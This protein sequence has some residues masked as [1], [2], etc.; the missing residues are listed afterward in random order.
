MTSGS[1]YFFQFIGGVKPEDYRG[2]RFPKA[3]YRR[4]PAK[5]VKEVLAVVPVQIDPWM[6]GWVVGEY[7]VKF[8]IRDTL[9]RNLFF[10]IF[11]LTQKQSFKAAEMVCNQ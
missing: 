9:Q 7:C 1:G 3:I 5:R 2:G 10:C 11:Y 8:F 4:L 6:I